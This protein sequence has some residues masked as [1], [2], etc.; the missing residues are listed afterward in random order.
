MRFNWIQHAVRDLRY[1]ARTLLHTPGF[2]GTVVLI[3]ALGIGVNTAVFSI[4]DRALLAPLPFTRAEDLFVLYE[5]TA[6]TPRYSVSYPNFLDWRDNQSFSHMGAGRPADVVFSSGGKS[7]FLHAAMISADMFRTLDLRTL[8]GRS[9]TAQDDQL[10]AGRVAMLDEDFWRNRFGAATDVIGR[11]LRVKGSAYTVV[12]I[13]PR[14]V[15][16]L[17]RI[18][19]PAELYIPLG[20]WDDPS[21]RNRKVTTGMYVVARLRPGVS[22]TNARADM[23][24]IAANLAETYPDENRGIGITF[25]TLRQMLVFRIRIALLVLLGAVAFV[26]LIACADIANLILVRSGLRAREFAT[27][28]ALGAGVGHLTRQLLMENALLAAIG[29]AAGLGLC[30]VTLRTIISKLPADIPGVNQGGIDARVALWALGLS[31]LMALACSV[32]PALNVFRA[33][34][35]ESLKNGARSS[36]AKGQSTQPMLVIVQLSLALVLLAGSGLMIRSVMNLWRSRPGFDPRNLLTF[37]VMPPSKLASDATGMR[38]FLRNLSERINGVSGVESAA[39]LLDPLPL[40]GLADVVQLQRE[41]KKERD[42]KGKPSGIWYFVGPAYFSTMRIPLLL[43]RAFTEHDNE[44]SSHVMLIDENLARSLFGSENPIGKRLDVDFVGLTEVI[45]VVGHAN[46]WNPGGDPVEFVT[47]QMY[48]PYTQ[49]A[50]N[51]LKV[52]TSDGVNVVARTR[53]EPLVLVRPI[54]EQTRLDAGQAIY[55]E[56]SMDQILES[57]MATRQFLMLLFSVFAAL[58]LM[59]ATAGTYGVLAYALGKRAREIGIRMALGAQPAD[60]LRLVLRYGGKLIVS[61][62]ILGVGIA[63]ALVRL[64]AGQ[65]YG[66]RPGDPFTFVSAVLVL[67][68]VAVGACYIPTRRAMRVDPVVVLR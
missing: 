43:G 23:E 30:A 44:R 56:R 49:L 14:A 10:G 66:V 68:A 12:G 45:G 65:L 52:G 1:G 31:G 50:D 60:I 38:A 55:G 57:W 62:I 5:K 32:A 61:G 64:I 2:S 11:V 39:I 3:I 26:W 19:G 46:H 34:L 25:E 4:V 35:S 58:A 51:W 24:R 28:T 67:V 7:E 20:Q 41:G 6:M 59:L 47:R 54:R 17:G 53:G 40:S 37:S 16:M 29:G 33:D 63:L 27:R 22:E 42:A 18:T 13:A 36:S 15:H 21:F 8:A 48:F 9:F